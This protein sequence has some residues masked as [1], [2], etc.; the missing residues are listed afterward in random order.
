MH[1]TTYIDFDS[2][3]LEMGVTLI[4][5]FLGNLYFREIHT[6]NRAHMQARHYLPFALISNIQNHGCFVLMA[7]AITSLA[8]MAFTLKSG[9]PLRFQAVRRNLFALHN[10]FINMI[11]YTYRPNPSSTESHVRI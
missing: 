4:A 5:R 1:A 7:F 11:L 10:C 9:V 2:S 3:A 8:F 6:Y